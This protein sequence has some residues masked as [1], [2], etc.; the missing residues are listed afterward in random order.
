M[1]EMF[2]FSQVTNVTFMNEN[3]FIHRSYPKLAYGSIYVAICDNMSA[4]GVADLKAGQ[5][6]KCTRE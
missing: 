6:K 1:N 2:F 5:C 4:I 3:N